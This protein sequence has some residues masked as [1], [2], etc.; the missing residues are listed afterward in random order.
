M[1]LNRFA[2]PVGL[3]RPAFYVPRTKM[4]R[5]AHDNSGRSPES[6]DQKWN[7][8]LETFPEAAAIPR[9]GTRLRHS[10][11]ARMAPMRR[12]PF[13]LAAPSASGAGRWL[14]GSAET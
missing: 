2:L 11:V 3:G 7:R 1:Q 6:A 5:P 4:G 14:C 9:T 8:A 12:E 10:R 13:A